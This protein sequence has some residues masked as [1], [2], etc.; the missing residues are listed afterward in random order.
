MFAAVGKRG[1]DCGVCPPARD[2]EIGDAGNPG[3]TGIKGQSGFP[4]IP[5]LHGQKGAPGFPGTSGLRG[6]PVSMPLPNYTAFLQYCALR[7][8]KSNVE[9]ASFILF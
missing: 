7:V 5:G 6:L 1:D 8:Q 4:G 9:L 3:F 2:G